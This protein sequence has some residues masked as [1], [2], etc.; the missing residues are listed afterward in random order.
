M[1]DAAA[2]AFYSGVVYLAFI[3]SV[4][5]R[6]DNPITKGSMRVLAVAFVVLVVE[7]YRIGPL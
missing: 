6:R 5:F 2:I 7:S 1:S 4:A 3:G